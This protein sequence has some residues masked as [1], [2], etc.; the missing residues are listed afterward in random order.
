VRRLGKRRCGHFFRN[1]KLK[2]FEE[3]EDKKEK[4]RRKVM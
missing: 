4:E 2:G 3:E 1:R